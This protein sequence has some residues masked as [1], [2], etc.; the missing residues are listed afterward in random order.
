MLQ[1]SE[2]L[3]KINEHKKIFFFLDLDINEF[4][5]HQINLF[6]NIDNTF[7]LQR[8]FRQSEDSNIMQLKD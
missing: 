8:E 6:Y 1:Q 5:N 4:S 3:Q 2:N 7:C